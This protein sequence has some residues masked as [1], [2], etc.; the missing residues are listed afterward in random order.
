MQ[1]FHFAG[2]LPA[3]LESRCNIA[4]WGFSR[5][6]AIEN[7]FGKICEK[8]PFL[9]FNIHRNSWPSLFNE[10]LFMVSVSGAQDTHRRRCVSFWHRT[11]S[12]KHKEACCM[13]RG[14]S[15]IIIIFTMKILVIRIRALRL[16]LP[17]R[18]CVQRLVRSLNFYCEKKNRDTLC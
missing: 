16:K 13:K 10:T 7:K 9:T 6:Y 15:I 5:I 2:Q 11:T 1:I 3:A 14:S 17:S 18:D 4:Q 8:S 12:L